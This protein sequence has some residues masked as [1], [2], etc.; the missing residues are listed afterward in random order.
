MNEITELHFSCEDALQDTGWH[1]DGEPC[2][3]SSP[4]R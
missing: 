1:T 3:S 4:T 2:Q